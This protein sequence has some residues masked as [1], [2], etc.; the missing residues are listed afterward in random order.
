MHQP[1]GVL[2]RF[3]RRT[4][5]IATYKKGDLHCESQAFRKQIKEN[6]RKPQTRYTNP[7]RPKRKSQSKKRKDK[8]IDADLDI[9]V[10][11]EDEEKS[12]L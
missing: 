10:E 11:V 3:V 5:C 6:K 7:P 2:R 9:E 1:V 4:T 8:D 12:S